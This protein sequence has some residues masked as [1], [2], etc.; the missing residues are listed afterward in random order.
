MTA[1]HD[2]DRRSHE[3]IMAAVADPAELVARLRD[4]YA[5]RDRADRTSRE[6]M[7]LH[8]GMLCGVVLR[9]HEREAG[10]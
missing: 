4:H 9:L 10:E 8:I 1:P 5:D 6:A 7:Y 3:Q 2:D